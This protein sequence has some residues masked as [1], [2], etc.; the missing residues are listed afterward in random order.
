MSLLA[1]FSQRVAQLKTLK[2]LWQVLSPRRRR[3]LLG[4]QILSLA[5]AASEVANLSALLPVLRLIASPT[6]GLEAVGPL[7]TPLQ[8]LSEQHLLLILG[9]GF[10]LVVALSTTLRM[11]TIRAQQQYDC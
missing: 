9:L 1:L 5:A 11:I 6:E 8:A 10:V 2:S 3:Q 7:T 4:L